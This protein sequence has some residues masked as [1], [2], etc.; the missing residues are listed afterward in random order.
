MDFIKEIF[1]SNKLNKLKMNVIQ[2]F[3][4]IEVYSEVWFDETGRAYITYLATI[5]GVNNLNN[6]KY[7]FTIKYGTKTIVR[8]P[9][10]IETSYTTYNGVEFKEQNGTYYII[11]ILS[12][13]PAS[14]PNYAG[15]E[16]NTYFTTNGV[17][18]D[19]KTDIFIPATNETNEGVTE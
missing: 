15:L 7:Y 8:I 10:R 1:K 2:I 3:N 17:N 16:W 4:S 14:V 9:T 6:L 13:K 19:T 12:I 18:S 5:T 11:Y